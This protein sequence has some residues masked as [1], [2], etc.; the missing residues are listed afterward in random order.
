MPPGDTTASSNRRSSPVVS[1]DSEPAALIPS[2]V[3]CNGL[4][5]ANSTEPTTKSSMSLNSNSP[6]WSEAN[7][8]TSLAAS[9]IAKVSLTS[10]NESAKMVPLAS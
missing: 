5:E 4:A 2:N 10:P 8:L 3:N 1:F 6:L 9:N 7:T